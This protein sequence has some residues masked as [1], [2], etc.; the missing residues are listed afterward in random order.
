MIKQRKRLRNKRAS[1]FDGPAPIP[2]HGQD[3]AVAELVEPIAAPPP[4]SG[5]V[6]QPT[7]DRVLMTIVELHA[8]LVLGEDIAVIPPSV[9]HF[10]FVERSACPAIQRLRPKTLPPVPHIAQ[11]LLAVPVYLLYEVGIFM[12]RFLL[13]KRKAD[14]DIGGDEPA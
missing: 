4:V 1:P 13:R 12:S 5:I 7:S 3:R 10:L 2:V 8:Q 11:T 6:D 14:D 9:H